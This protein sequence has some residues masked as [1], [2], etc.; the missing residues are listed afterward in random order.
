MNNKHYKNNQKG[1]VLPLVMIVLAIM[2]I[3]IMSLNKTARMKIESA[4]INKQIWQSEV[5]IRN[6]FNVLLYPLLTGTLKANRIE[7]G[8]QVFYLDNRQ[9][10]IDNVTIEIQDIAGLVSLG[11][12]NKIWMEKLLATYI[13]RNKAKKISAR[14]GDWI[15][16]DNYPQFNGM[17]QNAYTANGIKVKLRNGPLRSSGELK[18]IKG[19]SHKLYREIQQSRRHKAVPSLRDSLIVGGVGWFN[20]TTAPL[21]ALRAI[22]N[23]TPKQADD[24]VSARQA[25]NWTEVNTILS[26]QNPVNEMPLDTPSLQYRI[27]LTSEEGERARFLIKVT[28]NGRTPY[29]IQQWHFP[30]V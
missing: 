12:Y 1:F 29:E 9:F 2:T 3:I 11:D 16:E 18:E 25:K 22:L 13:D 6:A 28:A 20:A 10:K 27:T 21:P 23:F 24:F 19:F 7:R 15:D 17:E 4:Q 8:Q 5:A 14:L 26:H 30:D